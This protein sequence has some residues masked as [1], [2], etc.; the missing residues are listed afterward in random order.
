M[1]FINIV[2]AGNRQQLRSCIDKNTGTKHEISGPSRYYLLLFLNKDQFGS[3]CNL[4]PE[5]IRNVSH[6]FS[7]KTIY[8]CSQTVNFIKFGS[9]YIGDVNSLL[10]LVRAVYDFLFFDDIYLTRVLISHLSQS[11]KSI[12]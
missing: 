11:S 10:C 5:S 1:S 8:F 7:I 2:E 6:L 3:L 4:H 12:I 9:R